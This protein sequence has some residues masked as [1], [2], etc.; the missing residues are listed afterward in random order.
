[1]KLSSL[2]IASKL[3]ITGLTFLSLALASIGVTLWV[4]WKLEGGAGAVNEAG[5]LRMLTFKTALSVQAGALDEARALAGVLDDTLTLLERGDVTRPLSVPWNAQTRERLEAIKAQWQALKSGWQLEIGQ[6]GP[7]AQSGATRIDRRE[8]AGQLVQRIDELVQAIEAELTRWS[9]MMNLAQLSMLILALGSA[10]ALMYVG[11]LLVLDPLA[12]L[13]RGIQRIEQGDFN[14]RLEAESADEFGQVARGFNR[15]SEALNTLYH[16]LER[17]VREKTHRLELKQQRLTALYEVSGFLSKA[18]ELK[19]MAQGFARMLR[20]IAAADA[21]AIRW[22]DAANARYMLLGTDCLPQQMFETEQCIA[23]AHCHC[24]QLSSDARTRVIPIR[25]DSVGADNICARAGF[26]T[27]ISVPIAIQGHLL[28]EADL[29]YRAEPALTAEDRQLLESLVSH[30]ASAMESLRVAALEKEAVIAEERGLLA[31]ELHDSIAQSLVFLKMQAQMLRE[32][33]RREQ[34]AETERILSE[35]DAGVRECTSDVREL[36]IHFR[37]RTNQEDIE[38]ALRATVQKFE[39]QS[40][41]R[42]HL[43]IRGNGLPL[44][45][46]VQ[47]QVLHVIQEALSN[48]RKHSGADE[49]WLDVDQTPSWCFEVRDQGRG[50]SFD[51]GDIGETHVGLRIMRERAASIGAEL[52]VESAPGAGTCITLALPLALPMPGEPA[53]DFSKPASAEQTVGPVPAAVVGS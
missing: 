9:A 7:T 3:V 5:R 8:Q 18:N 28:G 26:Q 50:F 4:A 30:L 44:S 39:H 31:R 13:H 6:A 36:L 53:A 45:P 16:D 37:T 25:S 35:L 20:P 23:T 21:V 10:V 52:I 40:G 17:K 48:V 47:V 32:A 42:A 22:S 15:M 34:P 14:Y 19:A 27:L 11:Y 24:G 1:M 38:P 29:F 41:L 12:R 2:S 51:D 43:T 46:D 49:V 33:I